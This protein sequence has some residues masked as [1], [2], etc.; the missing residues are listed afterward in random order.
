MSV[1]VVTETT[2]LTLSGG[3]SGPLWFDIVASAS[4]IAGILLGAELVRRRP[5]HTAVAPAA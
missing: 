3:F 2:Y 1:L 4:L 5:G